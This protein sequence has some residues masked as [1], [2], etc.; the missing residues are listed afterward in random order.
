MSLFNSYDRT[1]FLGELNTPLETQGQ[2][3]FSPTVQRQK[4]LNNLYGNTINDG[5]VLMGSLSGSAS[6]QRLLNVPTVASGGVL[7][8]HVT[9][10]MTHSIRIRSDAG[11]LYYLMATT[12][13]TNRTGGG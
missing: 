4:V 9:D 2:G 6:T 5:T 11:T 13:V 3:V 10:A 12:T 7:A 8:V 1:A